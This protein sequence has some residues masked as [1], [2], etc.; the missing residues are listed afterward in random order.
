MTLTVKFTLHGA[1]DFDFWEHGDK[2]VLEKIKTLLRDAREH[3]FTGIGKPERLTGMNYTL[4]GH[5]RYNRV[6][7]QKNHARTSPGLLR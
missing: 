7:V 3:P 6:L 4:R 1:E 5:K 2:K